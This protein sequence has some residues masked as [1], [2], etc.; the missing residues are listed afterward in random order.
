M[1]VEIRPDLS[2]LEE[3]YDFGGPPDPGTGERA[4]GDDEDIITADADA[5]TFLFDDPRDDTSCG[6]AR[7][8]FPIPAGALTLGVMF[9]ASR[10]TSEVAAENQPN[11]MPQELRVYDGTS[12]RDSISYFDDTEGPSPATP[13][14]YSFTVPAGDSNLTVA[15]YFEDEG[16]VAGQALPIGSFQSFEAAVSNITI[17]WSDVSIDVPAPT[18]S[19]EDIQETDRIGTA[20]LFVTV[21]LPALAAQP[22]ARSRLALD[23][24]AGPQLHNVTGPTGPLTS[25]DY[26]VTQE[27]GRNIITIGNATVAVQGPGNYTFDFLSVRA[28]AAV[29][30][31]PAPTT[32]YPFYY[33]MLVLPAFAAAL[34]LYNA[35]T[36]R[37]EASGPYV[38]PA[39]VFLGAVIVLVVYYLLV[40]IYS[41]VGLGPREM[42]TLGLS[43]AAVLI[44]VQLAIAFVM[45]LTMAFM[46]A[47]SLGVIMRR[48]LDER[49]RQEEQLR[50]SNEELE[51]FA[52]VA[53]HDLQE[54]LRK[55]AGF[56]QLLQRRYQ[57]RLDKDA[58]EM[59]QYAVDGAQRMQALI[60]DILAYS[61]VG[62][63][64]LKPQAVDTGA[65]ME[66]VVA[67]LGEL[68]R[69]NDA[70]VT[71]KGL[72]TIE[73]DAGQIRQVLQNLVENAIKYR[74]PERK[75]RIR[76]VAERDDVGWRFTVKDNGVGIPADKQHEIFGIF[77][78]LHGADVPGTGIGLALAK[79]AIERHGGRM[80]VES[81]EGRGSTFMFTLPA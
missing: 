13:F 2:Q 60:R 56:T 9:T 5:G 21:P 23:V 39:Q 24:S 25:D 14:S 4:C 1:D 20:H 76:L 38:R 50:R 68:V 12:L 48:D 37:R 67:D 49:R 44:Y 35:V 45:L 73:A 43:A 40:A 31:P 80:W 65:I 51:R 32:V 46:E 28:L 52:Y 71:W 69:D 77:R 54:P 78:R 17:S 79:K 59:I 29:P 8:T 61:R 63:S 33:V 10:E 3:R 72:P 26:S 70:I 62:S 47:R 27:Q 53:S 11:S 18:Q 19:K 6:E 41:W 66:L 16:L 22:N 55:V 58:D 57:G 36:Y 74:S 75:P 81:Q 42:S 34:A 64:E 7:L 30:E 15:W